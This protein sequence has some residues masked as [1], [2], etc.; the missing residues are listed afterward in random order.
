MSMTAVE[1]AERRWED[2]R[3]ARTCGGCP[4]RGTSYCAACRAEMDGAGA[5]A[6]GEGDGDGEAQ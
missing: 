1:I 3:R 2:R 6:D 4:E 5:G